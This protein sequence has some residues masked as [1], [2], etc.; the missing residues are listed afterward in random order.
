VSSAIQDIVYGVGSQTLFFDAPNR[1]ASVT[2]VAVFENANGDDSTAEVA[3][4]GSASVETN[5]DTTFDANS[6]ISEATPRVCN[7]TATTGASVG[8]RFLATSATG[9]SEWVEVAEVTSG[10]SVTA[11]HPLHNDYAA[12]DTFESTRIS[13]SVLDAW[14]ADD[15]N[16]SGVTAGANARYRVRWVYVDANSVTQVADA[17]FDLVRLKGQHNVTMLDVER[18]FP[19]LMDKLPTYHREDNGAGLIEEAYQ[20]VKIDLAAADK[21]DQLARNREVVDELVKRAAVFLWAQ[22]RALNGVGGVEEYEIAYT[23]YNT[24]LDQLVRV[25][26][27][28]PFSTDTSG[29]GQEVAGS[30][31]WRR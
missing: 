1:P 27:K 17:Y 26:T 22:T 20:L 21:A 2:S 10:V 13:I 4:T 14:A 19:G 25:S 16:I 23:Q 28:I 29:A 12:A 30:N 8:R 11:K 5:P 6:G 9:E 3:T 15:N 24:R 7:L 18:Y 31:I